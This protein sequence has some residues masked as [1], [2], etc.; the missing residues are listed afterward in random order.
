MVLVRIN[1]PVESGL[2]P[3]VALATA[4][5]VSAV[6]PWQL[7][8]W[9]VQGRC[10]PKNVVRQPIHGPQMPDASEC[11]PSSAKNEE[12][13][14]RKVHQSGTDNQGKAGDPTAAAALK[15]LPGAQ[16]ASHD[17]ADAGS[18]GEK[19]EFFHPTVSTSFKDPVD[20]EKIRH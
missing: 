12:L 13:A 18:G 8:S 6:A 17:E 3:A 14:R 5:L 10:T 2:R 1:V 11:L 15:N 20:V 19:E 9:D 16:C 7:S 4:P